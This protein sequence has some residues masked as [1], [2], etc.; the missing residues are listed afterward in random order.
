MCQYPKYGVILLDAAQPFVYSRS[1]FLVPEYAGIIY[2]I[3]CKTTVNMQFLLTD[4]LTGILGK[5]YGKV[6]SIVE[7]YLNPIQ[8]IL[9]L[10]FY[11][12]YTQRSLLALYLLT[13]A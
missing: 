10:E 5:K 11:L 4:L 6:N 13:T 2:S 8:K 9:K 12:Q 1:L 7:S 3:I